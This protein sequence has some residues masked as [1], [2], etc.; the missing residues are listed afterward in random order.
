LRN[1]YSALAEGSMT[2]AP[3]NGGTIAAWYMTAGSQKLL[4][5]HNTAS[6]AKDV[7]VKDDMS[8]AVGLLGTATIDHEK[9]TLG[10]HSSVVFREMRSKE[11]RYLLSRVQ[12]TL[13][14]SSAARFTFL[15]RTRAAVTHLSSTT[16]VHSSI[17]EQL[18]L[19]VQSLSR[20]AQRCVCLVIT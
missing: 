15:L 17:S 14:Q 2:V 16:I 3:G 6:S 11:V 13:T 18:T 10:P 1:I 4:V 7:T 20:R 5:I 12:S 19:Q 9:L 8:R